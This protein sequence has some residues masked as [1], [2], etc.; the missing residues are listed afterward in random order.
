[1]FSISHFDASPHFEPMI[2]PPRTISVF[3][4]STYRQRG[5]KGVMCRISAFSTAISA[6]WT[7]EPLPRN[8]CL[9]A[10]FDSLR[11]LRRL[12]S[13]IFQKPAPF[14]RP[15]LG[16]DGETLLPFFVSVSRLFINGL[17]HLLHGAMR[18]MDDRFRKA[19]LYP[20]Q[21]GPV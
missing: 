12:L 6:F 9:A 5:L 14:G 11:V 15:L 16:L 21:G 3:I 20:R 1:M 19:A 17:P 13:S 10:N 7:I 2:F 8:R 18:S 4:S